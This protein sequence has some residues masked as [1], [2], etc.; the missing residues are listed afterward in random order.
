MTERLAD[1]SFLE[2][3]I[4]AAFLLAAADGNASSQEYDT[5]LDRL[6]LL[7]GVERDV[8]DAQLTAAA[9]QLEAGGFEP[10]MARVG[11]LVDDKDAGE[12]VLM[13]ALAIALADD[14]VDETEREMAAQLAA[15]LGLGDLDLDGLLAQIRQRRA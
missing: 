11:D 14:V 6:E 12:A 1:E 5:L 13:L 8:I 2:A 15:E 10:L 4:T 7:G 9:N 3:A